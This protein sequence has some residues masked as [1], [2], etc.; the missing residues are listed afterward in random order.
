M[1]ALLIRRRVTKE[2][3]VIPLE[4][5]NVNLGVVNNR[6]LLRWPVI[7]EHKINGMSPLWKLRKADL[8]KENFEILIIL[9]G[10]FFLSWLDLF[11]DFMSLICLMLTHGI[12][13]GVALYI[14]T[15]DIDVK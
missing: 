7:I 8:D 2:N 15:L 1:D 13:M 6:L 12:S 10:K 9:E 4:T 5:E 11:S 3:E 14:Y